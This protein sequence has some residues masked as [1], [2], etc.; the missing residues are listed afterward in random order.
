M[1]DLIVEECPTTTT[2]TSKPFLHGEIINGRYEVVK[3]VAEGG[4]G[5]IIEVIDKTTK[6]RLAMKVIL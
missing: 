1:E 6:E 4:F 2:S 3:E 5:L